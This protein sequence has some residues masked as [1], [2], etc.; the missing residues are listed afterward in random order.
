MARRVKAP[1]L[2]FYRDDIG[3]HRWRVRAANGRI[4]ADSAEGYRKRADCDR[5]AGITAQA[6]IAHHQAP[7]S[8]TI[9]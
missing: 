2:E 7:A 1:K 6:I 5:G 8:D 3:D 4:V 9:N